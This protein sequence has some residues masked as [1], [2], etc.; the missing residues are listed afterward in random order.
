MRQTMH[1]NHL[2][3]P[4]ASTAIIF[5]EKIKLVSHATSPAYNAG[6]LAGKMLAEGKLTDEQV[7]ESFGISSLESSEIGRIALDYLRVHGKKHS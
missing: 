3:Q 2:N 6:L 1:L 5:G 4:Q 7:C